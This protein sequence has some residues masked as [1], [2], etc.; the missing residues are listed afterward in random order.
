MENVS[1]E[2][3]ISI[4]IGLKIGF[5]TL[6]WCFIGIMFIFSSIFVLF[7]KMSLK[8]NNV[9]GL[10]KLKELNYQMIYNRTNNVAD[11][12]NLIIFEGELEDYSK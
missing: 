9:L 10:K 12:Y 2:E 7:P 5:K 8:I 6:M 11:L 3:N 4:K 1:K